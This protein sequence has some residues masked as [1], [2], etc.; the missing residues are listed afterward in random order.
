LYVSE[1]ISIPLP[2]V[3]LDAR[4]PTSRPERRTDAAVEGNARLTAANAVVLPGGTEGF[5]LLGVRQMPTLYV[6]IGVV[7]I[8]LVLLKVGSTC[9]GLLVRGSG[10]SL[11]LKVRWR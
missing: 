3:D 6:F 8:R 11:L 1:V 10:L 9:W 7:L 5:K 2:T 4:T